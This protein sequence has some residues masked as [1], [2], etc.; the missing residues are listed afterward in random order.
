V[1]L[2]DYPADMDIWI[3][4]IG[5]VTLGIDGLGLFHAAGAIPKLYKVTDGEAVIYQS[6]L[7]PQWITRPLVQKGKKWTYHHNTYPSAYDYYYTLEGDT[8]IAGK[9]CLMMYSENK[10]NTGAVVYEGA[11]YEEDLK[12][13]CFYPEKNEAEL[14]YDFGCE[15]GDKL[16]RNGYEQIL[17][18]AETIEMNG[19]YV[20]RFD[21]QAQTSSGEDEPFVIGTISCMEGIGSTLDF[22]NM[23]PLNGNYNHLKAFE[24]NGEI[25]YQN[26]DLVNDIRT[27]SKK[28]KTGDAIF[29]LQGRRLSAP[30]KGINII[31]QSDGTTRKVIVK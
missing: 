6:V 27:V 26:S 15:V 11:L 10:D 30:V 16:N 23:L 19:R 13:Y 20:K 4:G 18:S 9:D 12:V 7:P 24:V 29:N 14:L 28:Q 1:H 31:R 25:I 5:S 8:V 22:F 21:F 3:D 2:E 17:L